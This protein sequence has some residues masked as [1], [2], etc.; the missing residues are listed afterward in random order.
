MKVT[1][2]R[3][4]GRM[5]EAWKKGNTFYCQ[6][7]MCAGIVGRG[8]SEKAALTSLLRKLEEF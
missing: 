2:T 3:I 1:R 4:D 6:D 8:R 7:V 5:I